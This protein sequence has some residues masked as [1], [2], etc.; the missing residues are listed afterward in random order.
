MKQHLA[1]ISLVLALVALAAACG[2]GG[3]EEHT[4]TI[5]IQDGKPAGGA[6]TFRVKQDD[7]VTF[8][9]SSDTEGEVHL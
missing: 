2:G 7:T 6:V 8:N 4:F 9:I 5:R 3:P 1:L